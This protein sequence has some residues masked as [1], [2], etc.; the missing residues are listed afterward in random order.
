MRIKL[1]NI[2]KVKI[3]DI[4]IKGITVIAGNN[5]T[6]KSTIGK[7]LF[8]VFNGLND[9]ESKHVK[10]KYNSLVNALNK[11]HL[12]LHYEDA[13]YQTSVKDF[14][15]NINKS[16][17]IN[18]LLSISLKA[19]DL[20]R[21]IELVLK[22]NFNYESIE[23]DESDFL[24]DA[25]NEIKAILSIDINKYINFTISEQFRNEFNR[26]IINVFEEASGCIYVELGKQHISINVDTD[27]TVSIINFSWNDI[28]AE[29]IY[30]D[31]PFI[32]D[33]VFTSPFGDFSTYKNHRS[34][35]LSQL[36]KNKYIN[37]IDN[38]I[39]SNKLNSIMDSINKI[40][41]GEIDLSEGGLSYLYNQKRLDAKNLST[42][43]KTFA[44]LKRLILGGYIS[45]KGIVILDEPEIHLHPEWQLVL[46]ELII[47]LQKE[48]S[49]HILITTHSP[50]FL[51]AIEVY[52]AKHNINNKCKYYLSKFVEDSESV[53]FDDVSN[54]ID[55]IYKKLVKP[56][57]KLE[58]LRY[59][60]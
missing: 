38:I 31:N 13:K 19:P 24:R 2:A 12:Y 4:D 26:Q 48:F 41:P 59:R 39:N 42:G 9:I 11:L 34:N 20:E 43:I 18:D 37:Q 10:E 40:I 52:V 55:L 16:K 14:D 36:I 7:A 28:K 8:S 29:P 56:L 25:I 6:G 22:R 32:I 30:I 27:N 60:L 17:V 1:K 35:L 58:N 45:T 53:T 23:N 33:D 15:F 57:Q 50:Y 3:A 46:A 49:L 54:E 5:N 51:N 47:L 21:K 44:V